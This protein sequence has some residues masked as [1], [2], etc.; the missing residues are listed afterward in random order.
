[1]PRI[2]IN[3][4]KQEI[5]SFNPVLGEY[6]DWDVCFGE[7][8]L[9]VHQGVGTEVGG[10]LEVFAQHPDVELVGGYSAR[11]ITSGGT[12]RDSTLERLAAEFLDAVRANRD[13]DAIYFSLHGAMGSETEHDPEGYL[14]AETRK[15]VGERMPI[16]TSLDLHGIVTDR[17]IQHSNAVVLYHTYPHV[18]FFQTGQRSARLLLKILRG[19]VDP[20]TVRVEIPALVRGNELKTATGM[21]GAC[22]RDA[23]AFETGHGGLSGGMFIGNPFTDVPDLCSNVFLVAD[24]DSS[25]AEAEA[26]R[27]AEKFWAMREHLQQPLTPLKEAIAKAGAATGRVVLVDAADATSSGASGDSN[28]ILREIVESGYQRSALIP[29]VDPPAVEKAFALGVGATATF[30][31]GG[32]LDTKRFRPLEV[33]AKV[34]MLSDGHFRNESHGTYWNSGRTAVLQVGNIVIIATSKAVSLYD[35]SLFYA[36]GQDSGLFDSVVVKSPHCQHHMFDEGAELILNIDAPGSTSANLH[37][38][39]H[40]RCRRPIF[41]LDP[42]VTF[43][44]KIKLFRRPQT[45]SA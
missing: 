6:E 40:T 18:D 32:A 27:I 19:E 17:I 13:V 14:L 39:G 9:A 3:E 25:A 37:S 16:V 30:A 31:I 4:C 34:R 20:V 41:P 12:L 44:P 7:R 5:S 21:W 10:A 35:R 24:G 29:I 2:L 38:L 42:G 36:H 45:I 43:T 11:A 22:V 15:I 1:M 23:I 28:A 26:V 8:V 33:E